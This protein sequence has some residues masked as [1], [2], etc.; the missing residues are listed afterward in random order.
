MSRLRISQRSVAALLVTAAALAAGTGLAACVGGGAAAA[1]TGAK[2]PPVNQWDTIAKTNAPPLSPPQYLARAEQGVTQFSRWYDSKRGWYLEYLKDHTKMPLA[3][4]WGSV[5]T[6]EVLAEVAIASPSPANS[7]AVES[8]AD[9]YSHYWNTYLKPAPGY[10]PSPGPHTKKQET[11]YDDAGWIGLAFVDADQGIG[12]SRYLADAERAFH[13]IVTGG[14]DRKQGGGTWWNTEYK[15][16]SGEALAADTDLAARLYQ[17]TRQPSYLHWAKEMMAW[18]NK[19]L[20]E[21]HN[22]VYSTTSDVPYESYTYTVESGGAHPGGGSVNGVGTPTHKLPKCVKGH[23]CVCVVSSGHK[24]CVT[25]GSHLAGG[26]PP[27]G[28]NPLDP[29]NEVPMPNDGIG[30]LLAAMTTLCQATGDRSWCGEAETFAGNILKWLEPFDDGSEYDAIL[31]RGFITLYAEDHKER[32][33]HFAT[34][35]ATVIIKNAESAPG[36]YLNGWDGEKTTPG[37]VPNML[38]TDAS[39]LA[40]FADL[41]T[42]PAPK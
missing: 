4:L 10:S 25:P 38:R 28:I 1:A 21:K 39:S 42:V 12:S 3:S 13:F 11:W 14:W 22:G 23:K 27:S 30:A 9:Y 41:A 20:R 31:I 5:S 33:Y 17:A 37:A 36:V 18:A 40:V 15:L 34:S 7:A 29:K 35:M 19:H 8:F 2:E 32:W 26:P 6:L 24:I 16:R